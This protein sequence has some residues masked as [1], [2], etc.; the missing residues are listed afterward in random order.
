MCMFVMIVVDVVWT[1][2]AH[3]TWVVVTQSRRLCSFTL[4]LT[5]P[6]TTRHDVTCH[7]GSIYFHAALTL[8]NVVC[9]RES[10]AAVYGR[11]LTRMNRCRWCLLFC[12]CHFAAGARAQQDLQDRRRAGGGGKAQK[13]AVHEDQ[14]N[15][16][17]ERIKQRMNDCAENEEFELVRC[18]GLLLSVGVAVA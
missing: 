18:C 13:L 14:Y 5:L 9:C 3:L 4:H 2:A 6:T 16:A 8:N 15:A 12:V 1:W 10:V 7:S 17:V 11:T